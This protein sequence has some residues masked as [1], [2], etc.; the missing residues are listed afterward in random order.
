MSSGGRWIGGARRR[1]RYAAGDEARRTDTVRSM[2]RG[3]YR[4]P[5]RSTRGFGPAAK[6]AWVA[7]GARSDDVHHAGGQLAGDLEQLGTISSRPCDVNVVAKAH[8]WTAPWKVPTAP[9]SDCISISGTAPHRFGRAVRGPL[10]GQL[11]HRRRR[12][13]DRDDLAEAVGQPGRLPRCRVARHQVEG[14]HACPQLRDVQPYPAG[15]ARVDADHMEVENCSPTSAFPLSDGRRLVIR[16]VSADDVP[17]LGALFDGL[18][19]DDRH[20]RFFGAYRPRREFLE[21]LTTVHE[22]GGAGLVAVVVDEGG[23]EQQLEGEAGFTLL[24]NGDGELAITVTPAARGWLG[25]YLLD[26]AR[27]GRGRPRRAEPR[28]GRVDHGPPD[29]GDVA[30]ARLGDDR[31][32]RVER[33]PDAD[34]HVDVHAIVAGTA[35]SAPCAGRG[36]RQPLARRGGG[37]AAGLQVVTCS[38]QPGAPC[39]ALEGRPCHLAA[40]ADAIVVAHPRDDEVWQRLLDSH[41]SLHPGVPVCLEPSRHDDANRRPTSACPIVSEAGVVAFVERLAREADVI[42]G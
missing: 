27:P 25:P 42:S 35:R 31:A 26:S 30:V 6:S 22:R 8:F 20:S 1:A 16:P 33:G 21:R 15:R 12:W 40:G 3:A 36:S 23:N 7:N 32:H 41:A 24:P 10:V 37:P 18:D 39:P 38:V 28:G 5:L 2:A 13:V 29:A 34:R 4:R 19:A 14:P 17:R 11:S 9:A